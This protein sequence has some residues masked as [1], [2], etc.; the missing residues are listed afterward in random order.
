MAPGDLLDGE[1]ERTSFYHL[2]AHY[3][4]FISVFP[5]DI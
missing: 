1:I 2:K 3:I 5:S 4:N